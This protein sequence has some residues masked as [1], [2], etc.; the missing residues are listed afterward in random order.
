MTKSIKINA[1]NIFF[2]T[3]CSTIHSLS[4]KSGNRNEC[5]ECRKIYNAELYL[6]STKV[7]NDANPNIS[8]IRGKPPKGGRIII[9]KE[10][11]NNEIIEFNPKEDI[12]YEKRPRGRPRKIIEEK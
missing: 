11:E 6:R 10:D 7:K 4:E 9:L 2:C 1:P 8:R 12:K 5:K 3:K